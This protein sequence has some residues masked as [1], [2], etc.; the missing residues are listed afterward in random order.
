FSTTYETNTW[1]GSVFAQQIDFT[2]GT[3]NPNKQWVADGQLVTK[4][5]ANLRRIF[6][7]DPANANGN[8]LQDFRFGTLDSTVAPSFDKLCQAPPKLSQCSSLTGSDLSDAN[9]GNQVV[10]FLR[11]D[12]SNEGSSF[13]DR[14]LID[15]VT[16]AVSQTVL[17]DTV[18]AKPV[19][20]R[21]PNLGYTDS[22]TPNYSTFAFNNVN[23]APRVYVAANDGFLHAFDGDTGDESWAYS[24]RFIL[25]SMYL[26]A[27]AKY[28]NLHRYFVDG[29]PETFDVFDT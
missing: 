23:R 17:G 25:P 22:V 3:V 12:Q 15:P 7:F 24:P 20:V 6:T 18:N 29:S 21:N 8:K 11:G 26:L 9:D 2:N 28:I 19:F 10:N 4:A 14:Q 16:G 1:S 27:D 13:R 5:N